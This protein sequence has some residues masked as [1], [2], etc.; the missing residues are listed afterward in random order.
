MKTTIGFGILGLFGVAVLLAAP[1][2]GGMVGVARVDPEIVRI[3]DAFAAAVNA[4][5]ARAA[6]AVFAEDGVE[7]P[8]DQPA[9]RGRGAIEAY[10]RALFSGPVRLSNFRLSHDDGRIAGD[11]AYLAGTSTLVL[12][13][14]GGAPPQSQ[15]GKYVVVLRKTAGGWRVV[16][17]IHNADAP[18]ALATAPH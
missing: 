15:A 6:A 18:C 2:R 13:P 16:D 5:D 9:V 4:G 1:I 7:M 14:P 10:Y 17:A 8:A 12:T 3:A 11:V